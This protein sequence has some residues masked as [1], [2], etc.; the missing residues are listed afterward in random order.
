MAAPRVGAIVQ[1]RMSSTR[2]PGTVLREIKGRPL[3]SWLLERARAAASL[4]VVA[5]ATSVGRDDDVV[6]DFCAAEGT[7][8]L[9]GPL[10]DVLE[11]YRM[12]AEALGLDVVVRLTGDNPLVDPAV[13]DAVVAFFLAGDLDYASNTA[14]PPGTFPQGLDVEVFSRE[15]LERAARDAELPS[16]REHVTFRFWKNPS[17]FRIA[18]LDH[19]R[20]LSRFRLT[21]DG[22]E[23]LEVVRGVVEGLGVSGA[24]PTLGELADYLEAHPELT[25]LNGH[26]EP[27][28]GWRPALAADAALRG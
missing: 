28:A 13:V 5:V 18:K 6:A 11:R 17:L 15:A 27:H 26:V 4:D 3:L 21:V 23:D 22:P 2:L 1:A 19:A 10:D 14:P 8:C 7:A 16:E 9:R 12:A 24:S 20:D 25:A